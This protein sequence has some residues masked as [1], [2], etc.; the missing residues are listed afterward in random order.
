VRGKLDGVVAEI[1][2]RQIARKSRRDEGEQPGIEAGGFSQYRL[3]LGGAVA[4]DEIVGV[5]L[6]ESR[7]EVLLPS[8]RSGGPAFRRLGRSHRIHRAWTVRNES[9]ERP[10][11][12]R[13][14]SLES[15]HHLIHAGGGLLEAIVGGLVERGGCEG[16]ALPS[17]TLRRARGH[18]H[19]QAAMKRDRL[20]VEDHAL[21]GN[22][23]EEKES[24]PLQGA[25]HRLVSSQGEQQR[26]TPIRTRGANEPHDGLPQR[27]S[28]VREALAFGRTQSTLLCE[29]CGRVD[30]GA[31]CE[32]ARLVERDQ[33]LPKQQR[34][35]EI[36]S[37]R[38]GDPGLDPRA[39][40]GERAIAELA[41]HALAQR[42]HRRSTREPVV[43]EARTG[44]LRRVGTRQVLV[45]PAL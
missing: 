26:T 16:F 13:L 4:P 12:K 20:R 40:V 24:P 39:L 23:V 21:V 18:L 3:D 5:A 33:R 8:R 11:A 25:R 1:A 35:A 9:P 7:P 38:R 19:H 34:V 28:E 45:P 30:E 36:L 32:S 27:G 10:S 29:L 22:R 2:C 14:T 31:R 6:G 43:E 42:S 17:P 15:R 44:E 41:H 37:H